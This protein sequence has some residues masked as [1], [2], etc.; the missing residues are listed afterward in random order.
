MRPPNE[1]GIPH[2]CGDALRLRRVMANLSTVALAEKVGVSSST[3]ARWES[4]FNA[5]T[6]E[7][8]KLLAE[9]LDVKPRVFSREPK[10]S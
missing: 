10:I 5:P 7:H 4:E 6:A 8:V 2:W 9:A 3:L 1:P